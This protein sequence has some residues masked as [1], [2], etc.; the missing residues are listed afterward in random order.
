M[1][2]LVIAVIGLPLNVVLVTEIG[3]RMTRLVQRLVAACFNYEN[4]DGYISKKEVA[5][6]VGL[7]M[8]VFAII[9]AVSFMFIEGRY[10]EKIFQ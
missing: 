9:P 10:C 5:I 6:L 1:M 3:C 4:L 8:V 2:T 7:G